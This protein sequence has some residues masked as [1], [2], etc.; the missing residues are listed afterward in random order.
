VLAGLGSFTAYDLGM[1][2]GGRV[3]LFHWLIALPAMGIALYALWRKR[4][5]Q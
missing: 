1:R 3:A 5:R 4:S 2:L